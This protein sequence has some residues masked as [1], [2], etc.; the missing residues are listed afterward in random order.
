MIAVKMQE[1][2]IHDP[3]KPWGHWLRLEPEDIDGM[4]YV[5]FDGTR[6]P[7]IRHA[8][9]CGRLNMP[10]F[11]EK[12]PDDQLEIIQIALTARI[13]GAGGR[14]MYHDVLSLDHYRFLHQWLVSERLL[15]LTESRSP[16][17]GRLTAEGMS[18]VRMLD[19]TRPHPVRHQ[20]PGRATIDLLVDIV[21]EP[22]KGEERRRR[23][24]EQAQ[25]WNAAF[26]RRSLAGRPAVILAKRGDGPMPIMKTVWM[27]RLP[28]VRSRDALYDW[29]CDHL[30]RWPAWGQIAERYNGQELTNHLLSVMI[31]DRSVIHPEKDR[32]T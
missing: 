7:T 30:D 27:L 21:T 10:L 1:H 2:A 25:A 6:H 26:L 24:E 28:D 19:V 22:A 9:W 16:L 14:P 23:V 11:A 13:R 29:L 17:D 20:K 12:V 32:C 15:M 18:V 4:S 5:D 8:F 31:A 3:E